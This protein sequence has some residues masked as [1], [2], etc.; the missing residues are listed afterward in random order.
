MIRNATMTEKQMENVMIIRPMELRD[1]E[2]VAKIESICFTMPWSEKSYRDTL[3]NGNALYLVAE[4]EDTKEIVGM[5]GVLK[6]IDEGDVSN[7]AVHPDYRRKNVAKQMMKE[8]LARG[9]SFGIDAFTLEVR[10]GNEAA[11]KLYEHFGFR[12]EGVRKNF[13][14]KPVEDALIMWKRK[15]DR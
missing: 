9:Q 7:V 8:L 6:I 1:V 5:C 12:T 13:Y 3:A 10:A 11:V 4:T 14:D 2:A 15:E